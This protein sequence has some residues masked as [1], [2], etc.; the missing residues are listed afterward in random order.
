MTKF[1]TIS[2]KNTQQNR[3]KGELSQLDEEPLQNTHN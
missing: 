2:N 3:N 1:N